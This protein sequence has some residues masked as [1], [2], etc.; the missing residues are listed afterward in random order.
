MKVSRFAVP[1]RANSRLW[2]HPTINPFRP[3]VVIDTFNPVPIVITG[4]YNLTPGD[5][6]QRVG[7]TSQVGSIT[8]TQTPGGFTIQRLF[9]R[10]SNGKITLKIDN[11]T[12]TYVGNVSIDYGVGPDASLVYEGAGVW[13]GI[14]TEFRDLLMAVEQN[15]ASLNIFLGAD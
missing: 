3:P 6:G 2:Q 7:F 15:N 8:P 5:Q 14:S 13:S 12:G 4:S 11:Y 1:N 10:K 9:A